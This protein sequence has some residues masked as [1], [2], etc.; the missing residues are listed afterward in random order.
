MTHG[1]KQA[2]AIKPIENRVDTLAEKH[3]IVLLLRLLFNAEIKRKSNALPGLFQRTL[4]DLSRLFCFN[5]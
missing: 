1:F 3:L 4:D 5:I 2:I